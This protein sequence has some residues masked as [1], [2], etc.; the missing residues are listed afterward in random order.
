M[1]N[2]V[3]NIYIHGKKS[4]LSSILPLLVFLSFIW[5]NL[6]TSVASVTEIALLQGDTYLVFG[7]ILK[8]V[9]DYFVFEILFYIYRFLIGFSIYSFMIPKNVM[10]D[11]FRL[12]YLIRN[13]ILGFLFNLR[14]FFPYLTVYLCI[15]EL[16]FNFLFIFGLYFHLEKSYVEPLVGQFVFK[17]LAFPV[18]IYEIYR[19]VLLMVGVL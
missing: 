1:Q 5:L 10:K 18:I 19:V 12:W 15:F 16:S 13:V 4:I 6:Y 2:T 7:I 3:N 17:T 8:G 14:F 9:L 11:K